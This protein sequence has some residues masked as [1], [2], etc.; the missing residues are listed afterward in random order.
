M[1]TDTHL[2]RY[3][4]TLIWGL[5]TARTNPFHK[6]DIILIRYD[7]MALPLAEILYARVL[8][9]G[10]N[11]VQRC[12]LTSGMEKSFYQLSNPRQ[13]I[14]QSPG[15]RE[16]YNKLNGSIYLYAPE[17]ITHLSDADPKKSA[18]PQ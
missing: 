17:S 10:L 12:T 3:A 5:K 4:D 9:M 6:Q 2:K 16:F 15:E 7:S 13:L 1:L 18:R 14:F 8:E 11:P